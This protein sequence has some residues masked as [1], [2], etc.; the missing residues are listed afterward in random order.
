MFASPAAE[1][2]ER[3]IRITELSSSSSFVEG[4]G[5]RWVVPR[6]S[7]S[8]SESVRYES[9][10]RNSARIFEFLILVPVSHG[11]GWCQVKTNVFTR[12]HEKPP[13]ATTST[14]TS[15][16]FCFFLLAPGRSSP[17]TGRPPGSGNVL[18]IP[19]TGGGAAKTSFHTAT[20]YGAL[21]E[22]GGS[23]SFLGLFKNY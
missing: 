9:I 21:V 6:F 1:I 16:V 14:L 3:P 7:P 15:C 2:K 13:S 18:Q 10:S 17:R 22:S 20:R 19:T 12:I 23:S 5:G 11:V 8:S 4:L